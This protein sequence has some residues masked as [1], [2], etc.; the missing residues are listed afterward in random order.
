ML[1]YK[2]LFVGATF[3]KVANGVLFVLCL[4]IAA[5]FFVTLFQDKPISRNWG[6]QGTTVNFPI[7]YIVEGV[8]NIALDLFILCMPLAVIRGLQISTRKKWFLSGIFLLGAL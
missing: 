5:F 6:S 3:R 4:W 1:F 7:L 8:T 2:S